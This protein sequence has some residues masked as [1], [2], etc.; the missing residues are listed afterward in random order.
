MREAWLLRFD[1][2]APIDRGAG[3]FSKPLVGEAQG[4]TLFSSGVTT[5]PPG[6]SIALH[7]HNVDEQVTLLEGEGTAQIEERLERVAPFDTTFIP[8]GVPHRFIN[9]GTGEM[10]ILWVYASTHVTR[11]Y[12]ETGEETEQ[13][14]RLSSGQADAS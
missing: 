10:S 11:T 14:G 8:A 12:V 6:A 13:F 4:S 2:V 7:T 5:F 9:R 3:I 1:Q